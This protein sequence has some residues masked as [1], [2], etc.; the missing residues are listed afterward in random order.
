MEPV[1]ALASGRCGLLA[2]HNYREQNRTNGHGKSRLRKRMNRIRTRDVPPANAFLVPST[3]EA[4]R[5][6]AM[7]GIR[8]PLWCGEDWK[9]TTPPSPLPSDG[10]SDCGLW[11]VSFV[12][13]VA[14]RPFLLCAV[15]PSLPFFRFPFCG[16]KIAS[17]EIGNSRGRT[18]VAGG[19]PAKDVESKHYGADNSRLR[20]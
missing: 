11:F 5:C 4:M 15:P 6:D 18:F 16:T 8:H 9:G 13:L 20:L 7:M 3:T 19:R 2:Q 17:R 1:G 10:F 14:F 12:R